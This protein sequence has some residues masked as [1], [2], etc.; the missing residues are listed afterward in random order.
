MFT[1]FRTPQ[2]RPRP[3][4]PIEDAIADIKAGKMVILMD[5]E[6][7]ENEGDLCM[8]AEKVT[9]E[10]INFMAKYGRG[11]ICLALTENRI[12]ELGLGMM[13]AENRAPLGTAFTV[14]IDAARGITNGISAADRAMTIQTAIR[15]NARPEDLVVPGHVFPLRARRGGVLVRTGQTEGSVDLA[16]LAGLKP[17]GVI[18]EIMKDDG[19]MARLPDLE[20]FAATHGLK[21]YTVAD[22]IQYRLRCDSLVH[23]VAAAKITSR[24][25]GE[26]RIFVYHTDVDDGEHV[27]LVKG[28]LS[29]DEPVLVRAHAEFLPGDV[30]RMAERDTAALLHEAMTIIAKEGK[31]VVLYLRRE[32]RGAEIVHSGSKRRTV[33]GRSRAPSTDPT[34][35]ERDFREYGI[36]AQILRDVGVRKIRLLSNFPRNLV[37]LPGYGLEILECVPLAVRA[38]PARRAPAGPPVRRPRLHAHRP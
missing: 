21:I 8:A 13:V 19:S 23:R 16:R 36:G 38:K 31:G 22:L 26:F 33:R 37:S 35:Q 24:Y 11:L 17:A 20:R 18:C 32:G 4:S 30:F 28:D 25:G 10:A 34:T 3:I 1:T 14:S 5:D 7:R 2:K 29:G 12:A 9:P 15:E 27:V 6:H